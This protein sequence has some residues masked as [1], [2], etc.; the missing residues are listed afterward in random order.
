MKESF[1][2]SSISYVGGGCALNSVRVFQWLS[3][4]EKKC[5]FLGGLG[6]DD[7]GAV[8]D[9]LVK[10][11]GVLTSFALHSDLPTGHCIALVDGDERTLCANLGAAVKYDTSDLWTEKNLPL[12][13][14]SKVIYVEG[15]FLSH[16]F[17]TTMELAAFART[18][19]ITFVFNLCGEYV[20]QDITYVENVLKILPFVNFIFGNRSEFDV[21]MKTVEA[22]L[23]TFPEVIKNLHC[24]I[25][26]SD[27][28]E[29][30][31]TIASTD[32]LIAI[33]TEGYKPVQCYSVGDRLQSMSVEVPRV[34]KEMVKVGRKLQ[35]EI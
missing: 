8:L 10:N 20:C 27:D 18:N 35:G 33:V 12:L 13:K 34:P 2:R 15:Y 22:K 25:K 19:Q 11:D 17:E 23:N 21:F 32:N 14:K 16:S 26:E 28:K 3:G 29:T 31:D 6:V 5:V 9:N 4:V 7:S 30:D 1:S 24:M